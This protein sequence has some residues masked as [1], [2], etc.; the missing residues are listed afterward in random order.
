MKTF[1][2]GFESWAETHHEVVQYIT[3]SEA[4]ADAL[5]TPNVVSKISEEMGTGGL[6][7]LAMQ[8]TDEFEKKNEGRDW[9]GDF[10]DELESFLSS[11]NKS[12]S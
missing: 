2:N 7:E 10:F 5:F 12:K 4:V 11:K 6:Y 3:M 9:D 8:W 1:P